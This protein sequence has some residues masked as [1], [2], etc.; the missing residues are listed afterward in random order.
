MLATER[1]VPASP[2]NQVLRA[3]FLLDREVPHFA[4]L[5]MDAVYEFDVFDMPVTVAVDAAGT[6]VHNTGPSEWQKRFATRDF[7]K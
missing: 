2:R 5:G 3:I 7:Q 4:D 6:S 1:R